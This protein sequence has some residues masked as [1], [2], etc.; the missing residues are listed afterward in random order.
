MG[1]TIAIE[2]GHPRDGRA[3]EGRAHLHGHRHRHGHE[4][5]MMA[6]CLAEGETVLENAAR[7]PEVSDLARCLIGMGARIQG[8]GGNV[9]TI[10]GVERL[11]GVEHAV[12]PDRIEAGT[13]LAAAA[14]TRGS[15]TL[16]EAPVRSLDAVIEKLR[17]AGAGIAV[18]ERTV[19]L[20]MARATQGGEPAHRAPPR[21]PH[22]H[23]GAVHSR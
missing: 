14:A 6:A 20:T 16:T 15:V 10:Q 12:M 7:E 17:E 1:A 9:I 23:A 22:R 19:R 3:P 4:N 18:G 21:L 2:Q 5:L 11:H 8:H 13:F